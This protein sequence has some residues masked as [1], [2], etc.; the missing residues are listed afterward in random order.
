MTFGTV[1][2][3]DWNPP[4]IFRCLMYC[5]VW[6]IFAKAALF[7]MWQ[8]PLSSF[9]ACINRQLFHVPTHLMHSSG[10]DPCPQRVLYPQNAALMHQLETNWP[11]T[12]LWTIGWHNPCIAAINVHEMDCDGRNYIMDAQIQKCHQCHMCVGLWDVP[13]SYGVTFF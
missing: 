2:T 1:S 5:R 12:S 13:F 4:I 3:T 10:C 11:A 6:T 8:P 7:A 9:G